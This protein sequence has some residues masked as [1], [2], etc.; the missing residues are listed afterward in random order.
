MTPQGPRTCPVRIQGD[1]QRQGNQHLR[2]GE[3]PNQVR[4][5]AA[6]HSLAAN[7]GFLF[8]CLPRPWGLPSWPPLPSSAHLCTRRPRAGLP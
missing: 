8:L 4:P 7:P 1:P 3:L 5:K 2:P 6:L